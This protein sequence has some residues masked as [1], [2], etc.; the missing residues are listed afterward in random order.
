MFSHPVAREMEEWWL[1]HGATHDDPAWLAYI[2]D[3]SALLATKFQ[4]LTSEHVNVGEGG[5]KRFGMSGA[6]SCTRKAVLKY[7]GFDQK[8]FSGSTLATFH[9]GHLLECAAVATLRGIGY[10]VDGTQAAVRIDPYM[11]SYSDGIITGAPAA[12][13]VPLPAILSVKTTGYKKSGM[14]RGKPVRM[15]FPALPF[16][17]ARKQQ[18]SWWAQAQAEMYG[19][20]YGQC[21]LVVVAKDMVQAMKNDPYMMGPGGNGSLT[22]YSELIEIDEHFCANELAPIW[23]QAWDAATDGRGGTPFVFNPTAGKFVRLPRPGDTAS[24]WG[25]PNQEATGT[26]NPCF[27][28]DLVESCKRELAR[29]YQGA[30]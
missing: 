16:E 15:G 30:A 14:V 10:T 26:F 19:G 20:G 3:L 17:G 1:D 21:L 24:G 5:E 29:S 9:I 7:L 28:C 11:H 4:E 6:G 23:G 12:S 27:G 2:D 22:F 8:P 25:G 13:Q 18:P